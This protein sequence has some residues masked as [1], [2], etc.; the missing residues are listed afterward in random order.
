MTVV[1][2][3]DYKRSLGIEPKTLYYFDVIVGKSGVVVDI[4]DE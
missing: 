3:Q 1:R 4:S 2:T